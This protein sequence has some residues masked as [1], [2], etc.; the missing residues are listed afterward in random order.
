MSAEDTMRLEMLRRYRRPGDCGECAS[1]ALRETWL[2]GKEAETQGQDR[3]CEE[4][5]F[6]QEHAC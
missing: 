3:G 2:A 1:D 4:V 6:L 5:R